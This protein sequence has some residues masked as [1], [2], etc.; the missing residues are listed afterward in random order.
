V[1]LKLYDVL[2]REVLSLVDGPES[3]GYHQVTLDVSDL[4]SGVYFYRLKAGRFTEVK[5]LVVMK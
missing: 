2:G 1:S 5:R 3:A 4:T